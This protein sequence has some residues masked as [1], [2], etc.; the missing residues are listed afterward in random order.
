MY[1]RTRNYPTTSLSIL[2]YCI[3]ECYSTLLAVM[4]LILI[5]WQETWVESGLEIYQLNLGS[6]C[7]LLVF[8]IDT[9]KLE[10][11]ETGF[12]CIVAPLLR[13]P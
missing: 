6:I 9:R 4:L 2:V 10:M 3:S 11:L 7:C 12:M 13:V 8:D 5:L 1:L